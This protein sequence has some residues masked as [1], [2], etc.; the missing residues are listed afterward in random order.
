MRLIENIKASEG[1]REYPYKDLLG[2]DTVGMGTKLPLSLSEVEMI[3]R[4]RFGKALTN[5]NDGGIVFQGMV[6]PLSKAE[7][8][9]LLK[10]RLNKMTTELLEFKP[11]M[12]RFPQDKQEVIFEMIYQMGVRGVVN[13]KMMWLALENFDYKVAAEEMLD[14]QWA[15]QTPSRANKLAKQMEA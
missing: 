10:F 3:M 5:M 1:F 8:E 11:I 2:I 6:F 15:K 14:S 7:A 4:D 12:F 9:L 13:F